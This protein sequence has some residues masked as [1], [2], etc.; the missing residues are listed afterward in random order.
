MKKIKHDYMKWNA[1][2]KVFDI[3]KSENVQKPS[4]PV[5]ISKTSSAIRKMG[6]DCLKAT[7]KTNDQ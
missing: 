4:S 7:M 3:L 2:S 5:S 1:I 6:S